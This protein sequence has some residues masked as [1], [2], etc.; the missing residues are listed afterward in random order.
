MSG[1]GVGCDKN[2]QHKK[3]HSAWL[4]VMTMLPYGYK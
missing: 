3:K 2:I 4:M 1:L